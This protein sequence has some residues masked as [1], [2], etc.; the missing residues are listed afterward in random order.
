MEKTEEVIKLDYTVIDAHQLRADCLDGSERAKS[1]NEQKIADG[2]WDLLTDS[3]DG[4]SERTA[5]IVA[6]WHDEARLA[7]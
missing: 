6:T 3:G 7:D 5:Y 4:E 2:L 1:R